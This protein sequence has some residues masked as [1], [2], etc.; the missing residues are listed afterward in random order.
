MAKLLDQKILFHT[1]IENK[2]TCK[3]VC[4]M[5]CLKMACINV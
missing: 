5:Q 3:R 2:N 1:N 4:K